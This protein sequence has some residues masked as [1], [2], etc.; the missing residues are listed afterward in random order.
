M[1]SNTP[2]NIYGLIQTFKYQYFITILVNNLKTKT[3]FD[4][5]VHIT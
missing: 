2:G 1:N 4:Q 5:N 3:I